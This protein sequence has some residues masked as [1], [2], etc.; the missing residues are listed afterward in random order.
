MT[1]ACPVVAEEQIEDCICT[2]R[3]LRVML[4]T[5]LARV[6]GVTTKALNQAV[7][8]NLPK[9]PPDFMFQLTQ[10]EAVSS[11]VQGHKL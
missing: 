10:D 2:L 11:S 7:N 5:D 8:Q 3:G 9:F 1:Q 4:D 6:Y